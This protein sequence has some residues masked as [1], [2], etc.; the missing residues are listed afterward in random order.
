MAGKAAAPLTVITDV[1]TAVIFEGCHCQIACQS[2][3]I[4]YIIRYIIFIEVWR[5]I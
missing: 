5:T 3:I 4:C 1:I 2:F